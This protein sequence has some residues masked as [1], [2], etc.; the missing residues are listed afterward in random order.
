MKVEAYIIA[1]HESETIA[2]TIKHYKRICDKITIFD[3]FSTDNTKDI[4]ESLG[5]EVRLFGVA[6][7]LNDAEYL[8]IKNHAW[9][10]SDADWVIVCDCDEILNVSRETLEEHAKEGDTI[11]KT[12]GWN[13]YSN[14]MPKD[15]WFEVRTGIKDDSYSKLICFNPKALL[16]I[17]YVYGCHEA[18]PQGNVKLSGH[19]YNLYHF[20]AVGGVSRMIKRHEQY[21]E[22]LS[23]INKKWGLGS[24][25]LQDDG[26]RRL[27]FEE[28]LKR[29]ETLF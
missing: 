21:R 8:K 27:D 16:E 5:C 10:G 20:R 26:Q 2:L 24:H 15:A 28:R 23:P 6:G 11:L 9:K 18:K 17:G 1:W 4:A 12:Q 25:Y 13:M 22:R 3:N 19:S 14:E 7:Q 29:S